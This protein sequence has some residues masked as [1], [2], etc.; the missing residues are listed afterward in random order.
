MELPNLLQ[1]EID[2]NWNHEIIE[3]KI[4]SGFIIS[5]GIG[6]AL[7]NEISLKFKELC[8]EQIEPYSSAEV[9]HGPKSLIDNTFKIFTL[10]LNDNSGSVV[11]KDT[12]EIKQKTKHLYEITSN[13]HL[14]TRLLF[15]KNKF[16]EL[17]PLTIMTKF[18][19][20]IIKYSLA[21]GMDPDTPRYLSKV[22]KTF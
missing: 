10:S 20:W 15:T 8:Q 16:S 2:N 14:D 19:P 11:I 1:K 22:T 13:S 17:D 5:R 9:M 18:Y 12:N 21:K 6:F 4:S 3:K 7:S